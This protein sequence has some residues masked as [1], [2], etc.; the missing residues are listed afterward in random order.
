MNIKSAVVFTF[1]FE[2]P[3]DVDIFLNQCQRLAMQGYK[4]LFPPSVF[5]DTVIQQWGM[6]E[7]HQKINS[8]DFRLFMQRAMLDFSEKWDNRRWCVE[9][10]KFDEWLK[11]SNPA[12]GRDK[13]AHALYRGFAID[14]HSNADLLKD[15]YC[16]K[17]RFK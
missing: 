11:D 2:R 3:D 1:S 4:P 17:S 14:C 6:E 16:I 5:N 12:W 15:G 13:S 8:L 9:Y 10:E 7:D